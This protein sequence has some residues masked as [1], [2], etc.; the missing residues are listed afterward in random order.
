[1]VDVATIHLLSSTLHFS[2]GVSS[3]C[4]WIEVFPPISPQC[5]GYAFFAF[6]RAS[7]FICNVMLIMNRSMTEFGI[8]NNA[9][10]C[11]PCAREGVHTTSPFPNLFKQSRA[12]D[13]AETIV[14]LISFSP[15]CA[16]GVATMPTSALC[17]ST[18]WPSCRSS[19]SRD[20]VNRE[21]YAL[22]PAYMARYA[23]RVNS[24]PLLTLMIPVRWVLSLV[25]VGSRT[26][27][28]CVMKRRF[29]LINMSTPP[30]LRDSRVA[31][32]VSILPPPPTLLTCI[33]STV[34]AAVSGPCG[35]KSVLSPR[36]TYQECQVQ[37]LDSVQNFLIV[38]FSPALSIPSI[39][40]K[41]LDLHILPLTLQLLLHAKQLL[42][43]P[44][45]DDHIK[46]PRTQFLRKPF[47]DP[48]ARTSHQSPRLLR[49]RRSA[50]LIPGRII[51][52]QEVEPKSAE[53]V[54]N[55]PGEKEERSASSEPLREGCS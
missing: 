3:A 22:V 21:M 27:V 7:S 36:N 37:S 16:P 18:L 26:R 4:V 8:L 50:D 34:S 39:H 5:S 19:A 45:M 20:S 31:I 24:A 17:I 55:D 14:R 30:G 46:T 47:P 44:S 32:A 54:R 41:H 43:V 6:L 40:H 2:L 10:N 11:M 1:M 35:R 23:E 42:L 49:S 53:G 29:M 25:S 15:F 13:L 48:I 52:V 38:V 28:T 12:I 33:R 9:P 51:A